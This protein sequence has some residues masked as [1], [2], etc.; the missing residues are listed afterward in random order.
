MTAPAVQAGSHR[1]TG[2]V[3]QLVKYDAACKA[4]AAARVVDEAKQI[5][6]VHIALRAY[7]KQAK[8]RQLESDALDIRLRAERRI[9]ELIADQKKTVGLNQGA[10]GGGRKDSPRGSVSDPRDKRPTLAEAGID[11][12]IADRAR[13]LAKMKPAQFEEMLAAEKSRVVSGRRS[14]P[15]PPRAALGLLHADAA[16]SCLEE[17]RKDDQERA[18]GFRAVYRYMSEELPK[19]EWAR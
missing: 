4:L 18:D 3:T 15:L 16:I 8:N 13:K 17:I 10:R 12:H 19:K 5:R 14:E 11:K 1:N 7:A 6:D 2:L 9:G